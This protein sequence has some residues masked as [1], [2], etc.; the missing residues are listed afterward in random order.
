MQEEIAE[1]L[2]IA[3]QTITDWIGY[4][5]DLKSNDGLR[6]SAAP[7]ATDVSPPLYNV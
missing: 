3:R 1:S 6:H 4:C 5:A 2:D 7:H